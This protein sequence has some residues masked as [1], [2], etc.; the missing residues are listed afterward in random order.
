MEAI[1][2]KEE[3]LKFLNLVA[4][5]RTAQRAYFEARKRHDMVTANKYLPACKRLE[6]EVDAA[7]NKLSDKLKNGEQEDLF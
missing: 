3:Q 1:M 2:T 7:W 6:K 4:E 5:M